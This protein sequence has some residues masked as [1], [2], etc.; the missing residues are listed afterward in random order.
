[1]I[2]SVLL[3]FGSAVLATVAFYLDDGATQ[4]TTVWTRVATASVY[5]FAGA[6]GVSLALGI[7]ELLGW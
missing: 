3:A 4:E 2:Y 6:T 5:T 7:V 1:M